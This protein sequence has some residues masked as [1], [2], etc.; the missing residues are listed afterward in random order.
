MLPMN[1]RFLRI[2][3]LVNFVAVSGAMTFWYTSCRTSTN[4][5]LPKPATN[6]AI[7]TNT[8]SSTA[9]RVPTVSPPQLTTLDAIA[10][11]LDRHGGIVGGACVTPATVAGVELGTR[12]NDQYFAASKAAPAISWSSGKDAVDAIQDLC[13]RQPATAQAQPGTEIACVL[14][15][16]QG[17]TTPL[18]ESAK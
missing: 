9:T 2:A 4:Q 8:A 15:Y 10:A 6:A 14:Q 18:A 13:A 5:P 17:R 3:A 1:Q 12:P 11:C 7:P 16:L